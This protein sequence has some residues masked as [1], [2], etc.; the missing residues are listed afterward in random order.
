MKNIIFIAPPA[1]GKGTYSKLLQDK[2]NIPHISTGDLLRDE[3]NKA[4]SLG[5]EISEDMK[6]GKLISDTIITNLLKNRL[7]QD[8]CNNGYI[9]D[10]YPRNIHQ[11][12]IYEDMLKSLN[13]ELGIVIYL[14]V[15]KELA[16][17]RALGRVVCPHCGASFNTKIDAFKPKKEGICDICHHQLEIR[18]DDTEETFL[19]RFD[20]YLENTSSL[21]N[22]YEEKGVLR[23]IKSENNDTNEI[24]L[25]KIRG[26]IND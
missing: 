9:L 20:T 17:K 24:M 8:D 4:T 16:L 13:K 5:K 19:K 21:I 12:K 22:Y 25:N 11:A 15:D 3:V 6:N 26:V 7:E 18:K 14:E 10:G 23:K 2:Y 1:A